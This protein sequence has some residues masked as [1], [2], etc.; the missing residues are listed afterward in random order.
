MVVSLP[1]PSGNLKPTT[2]NWAQPGTPTEYVTRD[3]G[4]MTIVSAASVAGTFAG[5]IVDADPKLAGIQTTGHWVLTGAAAVT[6]TAT[7]AVL[8]GADIVWL[9]LP[10]DANLDNATDVSDLSLLAGN[11]R[12]TT[13]MTW[14][15]GDF[16]FDGAVDVSDLSLLAGRFRQTNPFFPPVGGAPVPE[17]VTMVLLGL[18]GLA[19]LARR[20]K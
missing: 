18:G 15:Q 5:V 4:D 17:P 14:L 8:K 2:P 20:R 7:E 16:N 19:L 10:G 1:V 13:G 9:G 12:K 6:Y 3:L 11:F